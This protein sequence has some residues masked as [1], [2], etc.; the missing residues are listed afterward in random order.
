M[1]A[2]LLVLIPIYFYIKLSVRE[3]APNT[4]RADENV[5][6]E[7]EYVFNELG[8]SLKVPKNL[9][10]I[11]SPGFNASTGKLESYT[12]YIQ[13]YGYEGGPTTGDLQI[14]GLY[15][16]DLPE[17]TLEDIAEMK[18]DTDNY[19]NVNEFSAG[20]L[21]GFE[22]QQRG[23]RPNYIYSLLLNGRIL[24]IAVSQGIEA[25]KTTAE[26]ILKTLRILQKVQVSDDTKTSGSKMGGGYDFSYPKSWKVNIVV[27]GTTVTSPDYKMTEGEQ[28][29]E[30]GVELA[31]YIK[32]SDS[33][34]INDELALNPI[35]AQVPNKIDAI[36][37][38]QNA[39]R[40]EYS[41]EGVNAVMTEFIKEG[42]RYSLRYRF[43]DENSKSVYMGVYEEMLR[44]FKFTD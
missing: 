13:N 42:V 37:A 31:V 26:K 38:E 3:D 21:Q 44:T 1:G 16:P 19:I 39:I 27:N 15:Q 24:K 14:Y 6:S 32:K 12:F 34:T 35:T 33:S 20:P 5:S 40:Y 4:E 9:H 43:T 22:A 2:V 25:N 8:I 28:I 36:V 18:D 11:K 30:S 10:V 17:V 23:E 7:E 29:L 41:Y